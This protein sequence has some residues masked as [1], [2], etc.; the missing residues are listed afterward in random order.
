MSNEVLL[1]DLNT[2]SSCVDSNGRA[3]HR[4]PSDRLRPY[5]QCGSLQMLGL[6]YADSFTW[7]CL[8]NCNPE[9]GSDASSAGTAFVHSHPSLSL[10]TRALDKGAS[11]MNPRESPPADANNVFHLV[12]PV[13]N[14]I[15]HQAIGTELDQATATWSYALAS[16]GSQS[17]GLFPTPFKPEQARDLT[18]KTCCQAPSNIHVE[19]IR[20]GQIPDPFKGTNETMVQCAVLTV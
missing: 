7:Q 6:A 1:A 13:E 10:K 20:N 12:L 15:M 2:I 11:L 19:L 16:E 14:V 5:I 18:W 9:L 3:G 17:A 8:S 4:L